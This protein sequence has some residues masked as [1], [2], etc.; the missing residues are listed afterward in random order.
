MNHALSC[1]ATMHERYQALEATRAG[2][3]K[4]RQPDSSLEDL[5]KLEVWIREKVE[6]LLD[7]DDSVVTDRDAETLLAIYQAFGDDLLFRTWVVCVIP[8]DNIY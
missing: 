4:T 2:Y 6:A 1:I 3:C 8:S 7:M 5:T